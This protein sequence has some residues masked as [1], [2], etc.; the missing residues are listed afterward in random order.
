MTMPAQPDSPPP[1][2]APPMPPAPKSAPPEGA[3]G[4][5]PAHSNEVT[6]PPEILEALLG[7]ATDLAEAHAMGGDQGSGNWR[8]TP[9]TT[10]D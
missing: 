1:D 10:G 9:D 8:D 3:R 6:M 7:D 5:G 4:D 2:D